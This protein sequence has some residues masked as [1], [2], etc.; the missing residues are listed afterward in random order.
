MEQ[1]RKTERGKEI[2]SR[3]KETIERVL[4]DAKEKR[5]M[6][7]TQHRGLTRATSW[8]KLK[9]AATNLKKLATWEWK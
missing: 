2:Y 1:L 8:V 6:R 3:R 7:Y 9:Y 5:A 4:G